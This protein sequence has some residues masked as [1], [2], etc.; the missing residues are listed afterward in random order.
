[1]W[2]QGARVRGLGVLD[3]WRDPDT[4]ARRASEFRARGGDAA[5]EKGRWRERARARD[6]VVRPRG[7]GK[8]G[9][10]SALVWRGRGR[11]DGPV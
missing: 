6:G 5:G 9:R 7:P 10:C 4:C 3:L 2:L 8:A 11:G 1:M